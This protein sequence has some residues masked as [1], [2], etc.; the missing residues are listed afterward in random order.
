[1][2]V[3][4]YMIHAGYHFYI[5]NIIDMKL[6]YF[7]NEQAVIHAKFYERLMANILIIA[8]K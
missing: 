6:C 1:M 8:E 4:G 7:L 5:Q 2:L 3:K